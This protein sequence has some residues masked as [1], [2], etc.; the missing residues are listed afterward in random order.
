MQCPDGGWQNDFFYRFSP[1]RKIFSGFGRIRKKGKILPG[2]LTFRFGETLWSDYCNREAIYYIGNP[3][4][5]MI[6]EYFQ[7]PAAFIDRLP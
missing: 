7:N 3:Y 2:N 1:E 4:L 5:R 6:A